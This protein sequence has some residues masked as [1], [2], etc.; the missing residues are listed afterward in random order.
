[1]DSPVWRF[2]TSPIPRSRAARPGRRPADRRAGLALEGNIAYVAAGSAGLVVVDVSNLAAPTRH[3]PARRT[4]GSAIRVDYSGGRV[5]VAAWNDARVY[6]VPTP[7]TPR[8]IGAVRMTATSAL[9]LGGARR[10]PTAPVTS[11]TLGVAARDDVMFVGNWHQIL[12]VPRRPDRIAPSLSLPEEIN[13]VDFGPV[14]PGASA[15]LPLEVTN[16]GTAPLTVIERLAT[17]KP[18][19]TVD[20]GAGAHPAGARPR[21]SRSPTR[22]STTE[23]ETA[24]CSFKSDDPDKPS[25]AGYLVGNQPGLGV[26]R[27]CRRRRSISSMAA[28]GPHRRRR[29]GRSRC[30]PT[31]QPFDRSAVWSCQ[32]SKIGSARKY[33]D[34]GLVVVGVNPGRPRRHARRS[35][36]R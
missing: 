14:A 2:S 22:R 4:P 31:S 24:S 19:F 30:S 34:Q 29:R 33:K 8:F 17:D 28:S 23:K 3:R 12:L 15:T 35:V 7:A 1:M 25:R 11:R 21:R 5:F 36:D 16:Q 32:T 13:L 9:R 20:A 6:D 10:C 27:R 18:Q 26:G